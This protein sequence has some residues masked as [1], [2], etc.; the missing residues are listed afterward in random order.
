MVD[1]IVPVSPRTNGCPKKPGAAHRGFR[2]YDGTPDE[3]TLCPF[4]A[5]LVERGLAERRFA[6]LNRQLDAKEL[7]LKVGTLIDATPVGAA[8]ARS[9][10]SEGEVSTKDPDAG[11]TRRR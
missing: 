5:A 3:T 6:E 10:R 2:L 7:V 4:R 1:I 11:A 9:P 8:V